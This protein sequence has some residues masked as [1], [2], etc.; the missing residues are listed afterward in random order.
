M[1][2]QTVCS[3]DGVCDTVALASS[4]F[5]SLSRGK[6]L[7]GALALSQD[8]GR[9]EHFSSLVCIAWYQG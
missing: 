5:C 8:V 9:E 3:K 1:C 6:S 7:H 2:E 4:L